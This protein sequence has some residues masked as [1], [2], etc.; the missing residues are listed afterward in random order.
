MGGVKLFCSYFIWNI[1]LFLK[2]FNFIN[3]GIIDKLSISFKVFG[4][5]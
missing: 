5:N 3:I 2:K 4:K 1:I